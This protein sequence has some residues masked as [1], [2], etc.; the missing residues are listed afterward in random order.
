MTNIWADTFSD[1]RELSLQE[2]K[3][4]EEKHEKNEKEKKEKGEK[5]DDKE[6][7]SSKRWWDD[8][9]DG[10]GYEKGEVSGK[11]KKKVKEERDLHSKSSKN[12]RLDVRKGVKN[13]IDTSPKISE[14]S[15]QKSKSAPHVKEEVKLWIE[16]LVEE[17]Y[18]IQQ[19]S[20]EELIDIYESVELEEQGNTYGMPAKGDAE[21][22]KQDPMS[23]AKAKAAR[24]K[25]AKERADFQV[26]QQAQRMKV[27][28]TESVLAF[29][30]KRTPL[31]EG[32][33]DSKKSKLR[34]ASERTQRVMTDAQ[35][36]KAKKEA[37]RTAAIHSKGETVLTGLRSSG[38]TGKVKTTPTPKS[39]APEANRKVKGKQDKLAAAADKVL[40][41]LKK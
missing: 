34:P 30:E 27:S 4:K 39:A 40:K 23:A 10:V 26:A 18:D 22:Q 3:E 28:A 17:G 38:T 19:F 24:A 32:V 16:E 33:Y 35:R 31:F 5:E 21:R 15:C 12:D 2:K 13:K 36:K 41:D 1:I 14:S 11:F 29:V 6:K 8:D 7:K 9:G 25:V 37:E 20:L